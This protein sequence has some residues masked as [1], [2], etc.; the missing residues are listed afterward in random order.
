MALGK[1]LKA[2]YSFVETAD[3]K[4]SEQE[5]TDR[6]NELKN[7]GAEVIVATEAY[8][9]DDPANESFVVNLARSMGLY[10][11]G[12]YEVSKLYGLKVRTRT[13]VVNGSLIPRMMERLFCWRQDNNRVMSMT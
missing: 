13:A 8:S 3:A 1:E 2:V 6:I 12:G 10:A 5:I 9:V 11:T 7:A 4:A